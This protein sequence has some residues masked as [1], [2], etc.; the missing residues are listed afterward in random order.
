M[1]PKSAEPIKLTSPTQ[2]SIRA[3][4][5]KTPWS[6]GCALGEQFSFPFPPHL[7][8]LVFP[9][10]AGK[11]P[12]RCT[13]CPKEHYGDRWLQWRIKPKYLTKCMQSYFDSCRAVWAATLHT[14]ASRPSCSILIISW[15]LQISPTSLSNPSANYRIK[16]FLFYSFLFLFSFWKVPHHLN[17]CKASPEDASHKQKKKNKTIMMWEKKPELFLFVYHSTQ[18]DGEPSKKV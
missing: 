8:K 9:S 16:H 13:L 12:Q 1:S 3:L 6:W 4:W 14:A 18:S 11:S 10:A 2:I 17:D 7:H 15:R 5:W